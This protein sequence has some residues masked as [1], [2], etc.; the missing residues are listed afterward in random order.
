MLRSSV[1]TGVICVIAAAAVGQSWVAPMRAVRQNYTD[2]DGPTRGTIARMGDSISVSKAFFAPLRW[3]IANTDAPEQA[4][5]G[6]LGGWMTSDCWTWQ[7]DGVYQHH[8]STGGTRSNW[9]LQ[10]AS[11]YPGAL[12]GENRID[13]WLR[14]DNPEIAVIM[15]GTNDLSD[16][17]ITPAAYQANILAVVQACKANGTIPVLTTAPPRHN[18]DNG[19]TAYQQR[20]ADFHQAALNVAAAEQ[21]PLI[22][23]RGEILG[24]HPHNPPTDTWD[25]ADAMWGAYSGYEVPTSIARDGVHP[26]NYSAGQSDFS[27]AALDT[28]GFDLRNQMTLLAA[29]EVYEQVIVPEPTTVCLLVFGLTAVI[30]RRRQSG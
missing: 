4:A 28:N 22:E 18:Y 8:G 6:W 19:S 24:R 1:I 23:Y 17:G 21:I 12:P 9:P 11:G 16:G 29:H 15:W 3:S 25:G 7:D 2:T 26:S 10:V 14:N 20:A 13:Y 30:R 5:L 27:E